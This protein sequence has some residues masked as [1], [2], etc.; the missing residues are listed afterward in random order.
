MKKTRYYAIRIEFQERDSPHLHSFIWFFIALN[1]ENEVVYIDFIEKKM[2]EQ[3]SDHL[4]DPKLSELILRLTKFLLIQ[5]PAGKTT[6][7]NV[8]SLMVII[9]LRRQLLQN[10]LI[11]NLAMRISKRF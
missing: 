2:N 11:L 6:R 4:K 8:A 9:L 10:H 1:I 5:E 3:L 7:M